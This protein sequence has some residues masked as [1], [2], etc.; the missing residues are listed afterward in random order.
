M[1]SQ[2]GSLQETQIQ[3]TFPAG[4]RRHLLAAAVCSCPDAKETVNAPPF[5]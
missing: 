4:I 2:T 3:F 1:W 5:S